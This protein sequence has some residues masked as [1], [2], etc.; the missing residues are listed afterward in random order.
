LAFQIEKRGQ[1]KLEVRPEFDQVGENVVIGSTPWMN[2]EGR[3]Q[4][5]F[6][7]ITLRDGMIAD[8]QGC[9]TRREAQRQAKRRARTAA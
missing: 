9:A 4:E 3:L 7:V 6:Q 8:L 2:A 5:R 1:R